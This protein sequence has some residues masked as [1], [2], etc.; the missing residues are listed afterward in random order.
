MLAI[1]VLASV[2]PARR[3]LRVDPAVALLHPSGRERDLHVDQA[4][5]VPL[6][7]DPFACGIGRQ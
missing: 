7:V 3:A 6:E 2:I 4:P 1:A 5:A